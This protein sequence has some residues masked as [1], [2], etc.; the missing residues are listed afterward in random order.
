ME[1]EALCLLKLEQWPEAEE[2]AALALVAEPSN[3]KAVY[4]RGLA[5]LRR[6]D[7]RGAVEDLRDAQRLEPDDVEIQKRLMEALAAAPE[8]PEEVAL[9]AAATSVI[10]EGGL[11]NEK[12]DLN[13]GRL[14]ESYQA[15][16][17]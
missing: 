16:A 15:R 2:R 9:A 14:A 13:E 5:R 12:A 3:S 8:A 7:G 4:R 11:Y 10:R 6:G 17:L 1:A